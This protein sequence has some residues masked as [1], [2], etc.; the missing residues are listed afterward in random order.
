[1]SNEFETDLEVV[2]CRNL[3]FK[4]QKNVQEPE[5][6]KFKVF[7]AL[8]HK[9]KDFQGL[10]FLFS[11]SRIFKH[12]QVLYEPCALLS[13]NGAYLI[14]VSRLFRNTYTTSNTRTNR[15]IIPAATAPVTAALLVDFDDVA[16]PNTV[17]DEAI[18]TEDNI[19]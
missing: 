18:T 5:L 2:N 13:R 3:T 12:I 6:D 14:V 7:P 8:L 15:T 1:M 16:G 11:N 10:E 9:F 19:L 17:I 4:C